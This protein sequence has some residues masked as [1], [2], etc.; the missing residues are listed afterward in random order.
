MGSQRVGSRRV[1]ALL[2]RS[3]RGRNFDAGGRRPRGRPDVEGALLMGFARLVAGDTLGYAC[4]GI[5]DESEELIDALCD[6][7]YLFCCGVR[8]CN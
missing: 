7:E 4:F 6:E 8:D 5:L 1:D 2:R 3:S